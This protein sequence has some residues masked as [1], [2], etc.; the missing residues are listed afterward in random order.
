MATT[1]RRI[2]YADGPLWSDIVARLRAVEASLTLAVPTMNRT[3]R[4]L[5]GG[6]DETGTKWLEGV[7]DQV[8][9]V[10]EKMDAF[11]KQSA[12]DLAA[13]KIE[14]HSVKRT[15]SGVLAGVWA[16]A[17]IALAE[18]LNGFFGWYGSAHAILSRGH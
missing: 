17:L 8:K 18:L 3:E 1:Q 16:V 9:R 7:R 14:L 12:E 10:D 6:W 15:F 5:M 4:A 13:V 2:V 11:K